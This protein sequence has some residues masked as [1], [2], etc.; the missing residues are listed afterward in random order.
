MHYVSVDGDK[1]HMTLLNIV[2]MHIE[3]MLE[4]S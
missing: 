1:K 3:N 4:Y 2:H